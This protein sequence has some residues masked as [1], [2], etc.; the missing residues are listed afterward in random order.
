VEEGGA[1]FVYEAPATIRQFMA[2]DAFVRLLAGPI[3]SGKSSGCIAELISRACH[4]APG[5][6]GIRRT[7]WAIIRNTYPE[8]RD[9]TRKTFEQWVDGRLGQWREQEFSFTMR[10]QDVEAEILFRALDRPEDIKKLL[11]L[12]LTGAWINEARE[13]PKA[14]FDSLTGRVGRFPAKMDGGATWSGI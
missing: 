14:V 10:F 12:E 1:K 11:S 2:S 4:Q 3:G 8:L 7:R 13:V 6:D 9:T 5:R